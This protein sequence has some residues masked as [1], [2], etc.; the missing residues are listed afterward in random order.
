MISSKKN[1]ENYFNMFV[2]PTLEHFL[3]EWID[4]GE[5]RWADREIDK[6]EKEKTGVILGE[7]PAEIFT[8]PEDIDVIDPKDIQKIKGILKKLVE[9]KGGSEVTP[10]E[11]ENFCIWVTRVAEDSHIGSAIVSAFVESMPSM[12]DELKAAKGMGGKYMSGLEILA[13]KYN[14]KKGDDYS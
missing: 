3:N 6:W 8:H 2:S 10:E 5:D 1:M 9:Y 11:F 12:V 7:D 14:P 4:R 13:D